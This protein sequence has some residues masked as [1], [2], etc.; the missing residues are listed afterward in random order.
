MIFITIH[1]KKYICKRGVKYH[2]KIFIYELVFYT[3]LAYILFI[4]IFIFLII[5]IYTLGDLKILLH[6]IFINVSCKIIIVYIVF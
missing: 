4:Y 5:L 1:F 3:P 6:I 2:L